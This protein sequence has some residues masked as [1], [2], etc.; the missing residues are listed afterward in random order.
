M[1]TLWN[2]ANTAPAKALISAFACRHL[3]RSAI[4]AVTVPSDEERVFLFF[5]NG[6]LLIAPSATRVVLGGL[7]PSDPSSG[8]GW[9]SLS[10][11]EFRNVRQYGP[12]MRADD[13]DAPSG[14]LF[15]RAPLQTR[16]PRIQLNPLCQHVCE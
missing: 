5:S 12:P 9:L 15:A 2:T 11:Q 16:S 1:Y 6:V 10:P 13:V 14:E 8:V 7:A 4:A 3:P